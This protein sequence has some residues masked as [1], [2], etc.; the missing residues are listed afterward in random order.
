MNKNLFA[1]FLIVVSVIFGNTMIVF[2]KLSQFEINVF[3]AGFLRF[4]L[5]LLIISPYIL[6]TKFNVFKTNNLKIHLLRSSLNFPAMYLAFASFTL[7]PLE[8]LSAL[9]FVVPL[10]VTVLAVIFLKEKIYLYRI[11]ALVIGFIGMLIILRPGYI[12]ITLGVQMILISSL[13][14]SV[15]IILTKQLTKEDNAITILAYQYVF[16]SIFSF[17]VVLFFW[18]TPSYLTLIYTFFAAICGTVFHISLN[19]AY[20]LVDV[21]VTQPFSFLGLIVAS[22]YGYFLFSEKP[23]ILT[24]VGGV[25]VFIGVLIITIR[26]LQ[27]KKNIT[28]KYLNINS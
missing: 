16:M 6:K 25:V 24:W 17:I 28:T 22:I 3:T 10:F 8:K 19:H 21:T 23:D 11:S 14:W 15:V 5:G 4:F 1:I 9:H 2:I 26:E 7:V 12:D 18:Q 13:I 20:K 27:L